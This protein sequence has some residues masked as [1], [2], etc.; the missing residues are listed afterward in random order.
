MAHSEDPRAV[1]PSDQLNGTGHPVDLGASRV[2]VSALTPRQRE[3]AGLLARGLPNAD[4]AEHLVLS[5]GTVANHVASILQRLELESRTQVAAWAVEH[6]LHGGQDR[7]LTTLEQLLDVEPTPLK[8]AMT[9]VADLVAEAL[10][11]QKV[12]AWLHDQA[13]ATLVVVGTTSTQLAQKQQA[14]GLDRQTLASGGRVVRVFL[15]GQAHFD[16]DVQ[17]D[18]EE[19]IA[20]R[21][22]LNVRS[23]MAVPLEVDQVRRGVLSAQSTQRDFFS[24][25]DL[26]F[27]RAVSRWVSHI[28]QRAELAERHAAAAVARARWLAAEE[29]VTVLAHDLRNHLAPIRGRLDL[30]HRRAA[31]EEHALNLHDTAELRK[32]VDHLGGLIAELLD[33]ACVDQGL[34]ELTPEPMDLA[35][36]VAEAVAARQGVGRIEVE[37]SPDVRVIADPARVRQAVEHLLANAVQRTPSETAVSVRVGHDTSALAPAAVVVITDQGPSFEPLLQPRVY[38]RFAGSAGSTGLAIGL[39]LARQIAEAH[40]GGVEVVSSSPGGTQFRLFLPAECAQTAPY[41][42]QV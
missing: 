26:H 37:A 40:G 42:R 41:E 16:G 36:V 35:A 23:Q 21:R 9:R 39:Y 20:V 18:E 17:R 24:E 10:G 6:G 32:S 7:L 12:D 8:A 11:A 2:L 33:I 34:F 27:L 19:L 5:P 14:C 13:T 22:E 25:R 4:I 28:T 38:E 15:T 29:L 3:I 30:V 1:R 31:R